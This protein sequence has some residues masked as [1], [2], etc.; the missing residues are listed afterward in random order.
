[1]NQKGCEN[2]VTLELRFKTK[3][4]KNIQ[5]NFEYQTGELRKEILNIELDLKSYEK[6]YYSHT[7]ASLKEVSFLQTLSN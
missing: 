6:K 7:K 5:K 2:D 1:M 4:R 3:Y